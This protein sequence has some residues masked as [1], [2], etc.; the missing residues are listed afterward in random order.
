ML[1]Y[2]CFCF[3]RSRGSDVSH[4]SGVVRGSFRATFGV[5]SVFVHVV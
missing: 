4:G 1:L 3:F 2:T 5:A